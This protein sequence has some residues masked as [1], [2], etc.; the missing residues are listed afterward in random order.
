MVMMVKIV[1]VKIRKMREKSINV[2]IRMILMIDHYKLLMTMMI[3][4]K[5][6]FLFIYFPLIKTIRI[7]KKV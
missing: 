3:M 1:M 7:Y 5:F 4:I 2:L 6:K